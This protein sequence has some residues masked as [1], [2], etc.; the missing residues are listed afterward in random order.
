[1][2]TVIFFFI[3]IHFSIGGSI[4][5]IKVV[6]GVSTKGIAESETEL[7]LLESK[8]LMREEIDLNVD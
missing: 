6:N 2:R 7:G 4:Q 5:G 3:H 8:V 1:M